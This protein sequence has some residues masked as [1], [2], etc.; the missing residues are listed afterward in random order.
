METATKTATRTKWV[1]DPAHS[2]IL[3]KV[4]HLM[5]TNVKG[6]FRKFEC[7]ANH[8]RIRFQFSFR[9][10]VNRCVIALYQCKTTVMPI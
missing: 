6:E 9:K 4:K 5:I 8:Q 7:G 3:F 2:E 1:I 10:H